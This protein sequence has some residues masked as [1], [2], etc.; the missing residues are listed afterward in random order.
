MDTLTLLAKDAL[1][2]LGG[3]LFQGGRPQLLAVQDDQALVRS[4]RGLEV[5]SLSDADAEGQIFDLSPLIDH[6]LLKPETT[7]VQ[8]EKLCQEA[9][10][11]GFASVCVNPVHVARAADTL[12]GALPRVCT[13]VGFPLGATTAAQKTREAEESLDLGAQEI[14]AVISIGLLRAGDWRA[15][16]SEL[17]LL[18]AT[19]PA[20]RAVLKLIL[21]TSLLTD[22]EKIQA[23]RLAKDAGVDFVKT[24]TGFATGG[25]TVADVAL[26]RRKVGAQLGVKASGGIRDYAQALAMVKAGATRLGLSS[27]L[28]VAQ[29]SLDE[30]AVY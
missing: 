1:D 4:G 7:P 9:A 5:I 24:S 20:G 19:V 10:E 23:C 28:A 17:R 8:V 22:P 2:R 16:E 18:R 3:A 25:A 13:V 15:V 12:R 6:T 26:L 14:D 11:H 30:K 21:E 27:S 29:G